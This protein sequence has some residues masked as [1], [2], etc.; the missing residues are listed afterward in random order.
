MADIHPTQAVCAAQPAVVRNFSPTERAAPVEI[1]RR[2]GAFP[3]DRAVRAPVVR[4]HIVF[5]HAWLQQDRIS[6]RRF[7][8]VQIFKTRIP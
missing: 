6:G 3:V 4:S 5:L 1:N 8:F 7:F 2:S